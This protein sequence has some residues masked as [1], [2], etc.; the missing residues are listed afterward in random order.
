MIVDIARYRGCLLGMAAGDALG[1]AVE[2]RSYENICIDYG[3]QGILGYDMNKGRAEVSSYTQIAAF[4]CNGLLVGITRNRAGNA[5]VPLRKYI[6]AA[7]REWAYTQTNRPLPPKVNCWICHVDE[8]RR[9]KCLD[10]HTF[11][12]VSRNA[13]GTP[14]HPSNRI[15]TPG[16]LTA[17][18]SVGLFFRPERMEISQIGALG[19]QTVALTHGDPGT[20]LSGALIAYVLAGIVQDGKAPLEEHFANA[21]AAVTAQ[22]GQTFPQAKALRNM[23]EK[24]L[25][26]AESAADPRETMLSLGCDTAPKVLAGAMYASLMSG[27]DFNDGMILSVNHSGRS[28]AV[29]ALTGAILG[30]KLGEAA[31]PDFYL[32]SLEAADVLRQL[33]RDL[34]Q[35]GSRTGASRLFD[36]DWDR[37]YIQGEPV[38][39]L[40]V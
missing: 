19:A 39:T 25:A 9:R 40:Q 26:L 33:A 34:I 21:A 16:A 3:P 12:A 2:W 23:V 13:L 4:S 38:E 18:V 7:L 37:K 1:S 24:V 17:A 31:L 22:F 11:E 27:G 29:G 35:A 6:A 5:A 32:E 20:F 8:L 15:S 30:A 10:S 14:L 36:D 28:A